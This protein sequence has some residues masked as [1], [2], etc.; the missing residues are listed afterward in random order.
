MSSHLD[1]S[2]LTL[3]QINQIVQNYQT[4]TTEFNNQI[5]EI[6]NDALSWNTYI[7]IQLDFDDKF[8]AETLPRSSTN[9]STN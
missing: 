4:K 9:S 2:N 7:Q 5:V 3:E 1:F 6:D 8:T